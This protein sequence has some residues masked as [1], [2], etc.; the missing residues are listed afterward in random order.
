LIV[1]EIAVAAASTELP[2]VD[3]VGGVDSAWRVQPV[4]ARVRQLR[5]LFWFRGL[6]LRHEVSTVHGL[7]QRIGQLASP[8]DASRI[9]LKKW[10]AYAH[11]T[12]R[13]CSET[14]RLAEASLVAVGQGGSLAEFNSVLWEV[15]AEPLSNQADFERATNKLPPRVRSIAF[16]RRLSCLGARQWCVR[17]GAAQVNAIKKSSSSLDAMALAILLIQQVERLGTP[18]PL[19]SIPWH[20]LQLLEEASTEFGLRGLEPLFRTACAE[21]GPATERCVRDVGQGSRLEGSVPTRGVRKV[22]SS[23]RPLSTDIDFD[24]KP[25]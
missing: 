9:W 16:Q 21:C 8:G 14:L 11:G 20:A 5:I 1:E 15:L 4:S 12:Q 10:Y 7:A 13:P 2:A 22:R 18:A 6:Q 3:P 17:I 19:V 24:K 25:I 23:A